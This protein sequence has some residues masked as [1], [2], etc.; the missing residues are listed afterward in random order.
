MTSPKSMNVMMWPHQ[1]RI[2]ARS[3]S[4]VQVN[5]W[6]IVTWIGVKHYK[7]SCWLKFL[8]TNEEISPYGCKHMEWTNEERVQGLCLV[9]NKF[10]PHIMDHWSRWII[11]STRDDSDFNTSSNKVQSHGSRYS[12]LKATILIKISMAQD[13]DSITQ[14]RIHLKIHLENEVLRR[15]TIKR[16]AIHFHTRAKTIAKFPSAL[17]AFKREK[18]TKSSSSSFP[19]FLLCSQIVNVHLRSSNSSIVEVLLD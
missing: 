8:V 1:A 16:K 4:S 2:S 11:Q 12:S 6:V 19:L 7:K 13:E 14:L 9:E 5:Q 17:K 3:S 18:L 15:C 10:E